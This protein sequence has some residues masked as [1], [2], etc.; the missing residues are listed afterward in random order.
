MDIQNVPFM[1]KWLLLSLLVFCL[2][3]FASG[4][5][6]LYNSFRLMRYLKKVKYERWVE[7]T[8]IG[9]IGPGLNN[10]LRAGPYIRGSLDNDDN[11]IARYK[12]AIRVGTRYLVLN[13]LAFLVNLV[14]VYYTMSK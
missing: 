11:R 8:S 14:L 1:L 13:L 6:T 2:A 9:K 7:I 4:F 12:G 10:P 5:F 3:V